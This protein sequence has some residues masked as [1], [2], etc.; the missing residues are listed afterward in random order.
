MSS[1]V[2]TSVIMSIVPME[3]IENASIFLYAVFGIAAVFFA[4]A[5]VISQRL[6]RERG[7]T[8]DDWWRQ[9]LTGALVIWSMIEGPS[10]LGAIGFLLT[11]DYTA[12][13]VPVTGLFLFILLAPGR[14]ETE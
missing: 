4:G 13:L 5:L 3:R 10:M 2:L 11:R 7:T 6:P 9:N 8:A 1:L 12:L 14:L